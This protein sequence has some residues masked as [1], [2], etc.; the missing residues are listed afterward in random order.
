M[1]ERIKEL[2]KQAGGNPNYKAFR[3]HFLPPPPDYIDP[4]TVDLEKFAELIVKECADICINKNVS[5]IDLDVIRE[6]GKFTLQDLATKSC[7][8]NLSKQIKQHFGVE[9]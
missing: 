3:G 7:G 5:N 6:S 2:V 1:N 4:A 9:E 8:E